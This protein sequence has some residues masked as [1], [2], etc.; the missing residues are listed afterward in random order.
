[1]ADLNTSIQAALK[2]RAVIDE[3]GPARVTIVAT[4]PYMTRVGEGD[5]REPITA[6]ASVDVLDPELVAAVTAALE[7][8]REVAMKLAGPA[9][10]RNLYQA[11]TVALAR[12]EL[13]EMP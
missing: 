12:G 11:Q 4:A 6:T 8:V 10:A 1:M 7:K 5:A 13:K 9:L 3:T 2:I